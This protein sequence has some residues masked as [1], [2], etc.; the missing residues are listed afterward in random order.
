MGSDRTM[1]KMAIPTILIGGTVKIQEIIA[2]GQVITLIII[3]P[4]DGTISTVG[5]IIHRTT[6]MSTEE[7]T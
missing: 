7:E 5:L 4:I 2:T 1:H 3:R 6:Q